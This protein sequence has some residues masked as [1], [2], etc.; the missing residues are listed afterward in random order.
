MSEYDY[1]GEGGY[2]DDQTAA[3]EMLDA[4]LAS[5]HVKL[6]ESAQPQTEIV[7]E[8]TGRSYERERP[9]RTQGDEGAKRGYSQDEREHLSTRLPR[10]LAAFVDGG[11]RLKDEPDQPREPT[12]DQSLAEE[13]LEVSRHFRDRAVTA[14]TQVEDWN[15]SR[16]VYEYIGTVNDAWEADELDEGQ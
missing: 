8:E 13:A 14:E 10:E 1:D 7:I 3:Q 11:L 9:A 4:M 12:A 15:R 5:G 6:K 16:S 2:E